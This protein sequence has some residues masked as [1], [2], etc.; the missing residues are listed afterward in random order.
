MQPGFDVE[1]WM[2]VEDGQVRVR[3][4][5]CWPVGGRWEKLVLLDVGMP[6]LVRRERTRMARFRRVFRLPPVSWPVAARHGA[7]RF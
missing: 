3:G 1:V 2:R 7:R 5:G 6:A 4:E